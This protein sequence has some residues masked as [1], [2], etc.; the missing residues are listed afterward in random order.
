MPKWAIEKDL[1]KLK[2]K[3]YVVSNFVKCN[4]RTNVASLFLGSKKIKVK[5]FNRPKKDNLKTLK[6]YLILK[7]KK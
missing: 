5:T 3:V 4:I 6:E 1:F 2:N 7:C